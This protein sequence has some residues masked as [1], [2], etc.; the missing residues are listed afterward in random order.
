MVHDGFKSG[1]PQGYYDFV[2]RVRVRTGQGRPRI[3]WLIVGGWSL[4]LIK[5]ILASIAIRHWNIP[6]GD[7]YVWGPSFI[8]GGVC[9]FLYV[10]RSI[11]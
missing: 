9:T 8:F 4:I 10:S 1:R 3:D 5:C 2:R 11:D 7:F 6:I